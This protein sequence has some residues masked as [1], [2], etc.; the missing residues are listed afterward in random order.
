MCPPPG[1]ATIRK[2]DGS[3]V[4]MADELEGEGLNRAG[5]LQS[6]RKLT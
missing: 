3:T 1:Q 6:N 5:F 2:A 4:T